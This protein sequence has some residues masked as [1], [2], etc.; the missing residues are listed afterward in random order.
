MGSRDHSCETCGR[1][2]MND[3][4]PCICGA[5]LTDDEPASPRPATLTVGEALRLSEVRKGA[6]WIEI[7]RDGRS[8][9][10]YRV[11]ADGHTGHRVEHSFWYSNQWSKWR[12]H[13]FVWIDGLDAEC[14]LIPS[15]RTA[16]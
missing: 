8:R 6:Q 13:S 12:P 3:D 15:E 9:D 7:V 2:G 11:L 10:R 1:G 14:R 5:P 4:R 16:P